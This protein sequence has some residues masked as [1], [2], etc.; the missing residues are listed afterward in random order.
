MAAFFTGQSPFGALFSAFELS[1]VALC[2][3]DT[4]KPDSPIAGVNAPFCS[5]TGYDA[6]DVL[7]RNCRFLPPKEGA[8]PVRE[9]MR[10]FLA[11]PA[12]GQSRFLLANIRKDG[13]RFLNLVFM[14][15]LMRRGR[16][17]AVLGSQFEVRSRNNTLAYLYDR[18]LTED[19]E[20]IKQDTMEHDLVFLEN[21][22]TR[23]SAQAV[24]AQPRL[25]TSGFH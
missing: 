22:K 20:R 10:A 4:T 3:A 8:G 15:K 12:A 2:L 24:I 5:L 1:S 13:T 23:A 6:E 18:A 7:G 9:R 17:V 16:Q 25:D 14:A 19:L 11:N 21:F